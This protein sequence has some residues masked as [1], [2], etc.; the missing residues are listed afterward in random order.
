MPIRTWHLIHAARQGLWPIPVAIPF[1]A[2]YAFVSNGTVASFSVVTGG[3][4]GDSDMH[5]FAPGV[6]P[7]FDANNFT[8]TNFVCRPWEVG[9]DES[10]TIN[11]PAAGTYRIRFYAYPDA[12]TLTG[13]Q[14]TLT[15]P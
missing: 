12:G 2:Y 1:I 15:H 10:C 7:A 3:G 9:S 5:I 8:Y 11:A 6:V 4:T 14:A 13:K